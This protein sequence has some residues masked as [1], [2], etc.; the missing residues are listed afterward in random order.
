V[1]FPSGTASLRTIRS[2]CTVSKSIPSMSMC[3]PVGSTPIS[4]PVIVAVAFQCTATLSP[5]ATVVCTVSAK[6]GNAVNSS[7]KYA[8]T[9][10]GPTASTWL[11]M[12][13]SPSGAQKPAIA[14][15]SRRD[16]A[17]K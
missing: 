5:S 14:S 10:F 1:P 9:P 11:A 7:V 6:S 16:S 8:R 4:G 17:A 13:S 3:A 12:C 15:M 2:S